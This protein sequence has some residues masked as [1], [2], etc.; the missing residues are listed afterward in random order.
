VHPYAEVKGTLSGVSLP[1]RQAQE[2]TLHAT[3]E[4]NG[5]RQVQDVAVKLEPAGAGARVTFSFPVSLDAFKVERPELLL[6]KVDDRTM[7]SGDLRFEA[8]K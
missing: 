3:V 7:I 5:E 1:L 2:A 6:I 8:T 4:L